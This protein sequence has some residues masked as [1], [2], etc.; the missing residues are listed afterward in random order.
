[1]EKFTVI[2]LGNLNLREGPGE[3]FE[4]VE[5]VPSGYPLTVIDIAKDGGDHRWYKID[6]GNWVKAIYVTQPNN[7]HMQN[8]RVQ[9]KD[10]TAFQIPFTIGGGIGGSVANTA[11]GA[12]GSLISIAGVAGA[13][14]SAFLGSMG[15][16]LSTQQRILS[17]RIFGVPHQFIDTT[18]M[19]PT[20][21]GPL[22]ME[23]VTNILAE[24]PILSILPGI[25]DYLAGKSTVEKENIMNGLL[26]AANESLTQAQKES[27][28]KNSLDMKFFEFEPRCTEYMT[29]VNVLCRMAATFMGLDSIPVPGYPDKKYGTFNWFNWHLSNAYAGEAAK[30]NI[31]TSY[32]D[33][34]KEFGE[35]GSTLTTK[36]V[37]ENLSKLKDIATSSDKN[38][39][40]KMQEAKPI[41]FDGQKVIMDDE[42]K[43]KSMNGI[44]NATTNEFLM[45]SF[46][47]DFF[48]KPPSYSESFQNST[49][50]SKF[51]EGIN[52]ASGISK[53]LQFLMGGAMNMNLGGYDEQIGDFTKNQNQIIAQANLN[54]HAKKIMSSLITGST[55]VVMGANLIFPEIWDSSN[56][57]RDFSL[58]INLS[59]PYGNRESVFLNIIVPMMFLIA[60]VLP[61]QVTVNSY[62]SP[63]LV[64][65]TVPG[66]FTC[67]MGMVKDLA[68]TKGGADGSQWTKDGLPTEVTITM[69]IGDLY[70][71]LSMSNYRTPKNMWNFIWNTPLVDYVGTACGLNMRSSEMKKKLMVIW[72]LSSTYLSDQI[73][74]STGSLTELMAMA[75]TRILGAK[76]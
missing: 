34:K 49:T 67:D 69:N 28:N 27:L 74:Y 38:F 16:G 68:I 54:E 33:L 3:S 47:I 6:N 62:S 50:T 17:R 66:F 2:A 39:E 15:T 25:P 44:D 20:D 76:G 65:C 24:S 21:G 35:F 73:D 43:M 30:G 37:G 7:T 53:E 5:Q 59:T 60:L 58:E 63:F 46:Y 29:Y 10:D 75:R 22:G 19:R 45:E 71:A 36:N 64:R 18:D 13:A 72:N 70:N 26:E 32:D 23:F 55:A 42:D 14:A 51:M 1:M 31:K 11:A 57:S 8:K 52:A 40:Q 12:L 9:S 61:R 48:I 56:Y 41:V 4:I